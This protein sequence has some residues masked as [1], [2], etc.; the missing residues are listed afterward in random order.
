MFG[1]DDR[2]KAVRGGML[3]RIPIGRLGEPEDLAG[4]LA[5]LV[6]P[7]SDFCTGQIMYVDGGYTAG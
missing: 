7:A 4:I 1:D 5:Y 3:A 6:S 2:A